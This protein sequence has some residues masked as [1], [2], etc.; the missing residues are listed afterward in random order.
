VQRD[1]R[2]RYAGL[3][4]ERGSRLLGE[5]ILRKS[6]A[7]RDRLDTGFQWSLTYYLPTVHG[8]CRGNIIDLVEGFQQNGDNLGNDILKVNKDLFLLSSR[9]KALYGAPQHIEE[10]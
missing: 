10:V 1:A 5:T 2:L 6:T 9:S 7:P 8:T 3:C 4:T